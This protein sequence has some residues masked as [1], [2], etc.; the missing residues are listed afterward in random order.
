VILTVTDAND[1]SG[2]SNFQINI[3]ESSVERPTEKPPAIEPLPAES[4]AEGNQ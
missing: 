4:P 3:G 2:R 1:L